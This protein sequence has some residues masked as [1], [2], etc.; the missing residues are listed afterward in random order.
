[1]RGDASGRKEEHPPASQEEQEPGPCVLCPGCEGVLGMLWPRVSFAD[2]PA[3]FPGEEESLL[4]LSPTSS[5]S[6]GLLCAGEGAVGGVTLRS[7][8]H[9]PPH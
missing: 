2:P 5:P 9:S 3:S 6:S 4:C 7:E 1:M 8:C